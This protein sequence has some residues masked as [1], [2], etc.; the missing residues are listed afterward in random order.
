MVSGS[1]FGLFAEDLAASGDDKIGI[2]VRP[3][4]KLSEKMKIAKRNFGDISFDVQKSQSLV[5]S[6]RFLGGQTENLENVETLNS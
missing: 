5:F 2:L 3:P 1:N 6:L 4:R